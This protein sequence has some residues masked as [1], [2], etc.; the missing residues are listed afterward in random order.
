MPILK[1]SQKSSDTGVPE[2]HTSG[3]D[4]R[5]E[6]ALPME[7]SRLASKNK[8]YRDITLF[9]ETEVKDSRL[10]PRL[11]KTLTLYK[12]ALAECWGRQSVTVEDLSRI[13]SIE[14][15]LEAL[16]GEARLRTSSK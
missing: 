1:F 4:S 9:T 2:L 7:L 14:R 15:D 6:T 5:L 12:L 3:V 13:D 11:L 10:K 8:R 16:C